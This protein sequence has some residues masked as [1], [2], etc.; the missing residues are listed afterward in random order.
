M[1]VMSMALTGVPAKAATIAAGTATTT[2]DA[3]VHVGLSATDIPSHVS[4]SFVISYDPARLAYVRAAPS[5]ALDGWTMTPTESPGRIA[6]LLRPPTRLALAGTFAVVTFEVLDRSSNGSIP[7]TVS[8]VKIQLTVST[9]IDGAG[10][11]GAIAARCAGASAPGFVF[12]HLA[13]STAG[14]GGADGRGPEARFGSV[15]GVVAKSDGTLYVADKSNYTIRR[16]TPDGVVSTIAGRVG[17]LGTADGQ[18]TGARF[19]AP[20]DIANARDGVFVLDEELYQTGARIRHVSS[21]GV[22]RTIARGGGVC[23]DGQEPADASAL[24][25]TINAIA[26]DAADNV[27]VLEET[28]I[29]RVAPDGTITLLAG[30]PG[31]LELGY[32]DG[33]GT[34]ARFDGRAASMA[35]GPDGNLYLYEPINQAVRMV[36]HNGDTKTLFSGPPLP[37]IAQSTTIAVGNDVAIYVQQLSEI[38]RIDASGIRVVGTIS[39]PTGRRF[40]IDPH[41]DIVLPRFDGTE[42]WRFRFTDRIAEHVAGHRAED[43]HIDGVGDQARF[44]GITAL[45]YNNHDGLLYVADEQFF[46]QK[47]CSI[48][49]VTLDGHVRTMQTSEP[50]CAAYLLVAPDGTLV[51]IELSHGPLIAR[52][53][54]RDGRVTR[55][56]ELPENCRPFNIGADAQGN[57]YLPC[58]ASALNGPPVSYIAKLHPSGSVAVFAQ[59]VSGEALTVLP[60]GDLIVADHFHL[61]RVTPTGATLPFAGTNLYPL[62]AD[63]SLIE[64]SFGFV[65]ALAPGPDGSVYAMDI[66]LGT[67]VLLRHVTSAGEVTTVAGAGVGTEDGDGTNAR[68]VWPEAIALLPDGEIIIAEPNALRIGTPGGGQARR[69]SVRH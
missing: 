19:L 54:A 69:R 63:G 6:V 8:D 29:R 9:S 55:F 17:H 41:G 40:A 1:L 46:P 61:V 65:V 35:V 58:V 25:D 27:Y 43:G 12:R 44:D 10:S 31:S 26:S 33:K 11:N 53:I 24:C 18:G 45:A 36:T 49:V 13:G 68:F 34:D 59:G 42:L 16:V 30:V 32:R 57:I 64:A 52:R 15:Y 23:W 22:V 62:Q 20:Q 51:A 3:D 5:G 48:R 56:A 60:S 67:W 14:P 50:V 66:G 39:W 2:C 47:V 21:A 38:F 4:L 37:G 7:L 28:R